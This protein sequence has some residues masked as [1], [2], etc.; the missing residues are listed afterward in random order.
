MPNQ[1]L[2]DAFDRGLVEGRAFG[3]LD[4]VLQDEDRIALAMATLVGEA[5]LVANNEEHT[6]YTTGPL[7]GSEK[8]D[9]RCLVCDLVHLVAEQAIQSYLVVQAN[10]D[11]MSV[12]PANGG[13]TE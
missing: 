10:L 2:I 6:C 11:S 7:V 4:K 13:P 9:W 12:D 3:V 5:Y 1:E 8:T